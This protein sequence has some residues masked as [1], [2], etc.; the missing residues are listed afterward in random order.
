MIVQTENI[1]A[2]FE[3][4]REIAK[5]ADA[6]KPIPSRK[7][8]NFGDVSEM[9]AFLTPAR[10][11]LPE[12]IREH[13]GSIKSIAEVVRRKHSAVARDIAALRTF[14]LV[15]VEREINPGHGV[16]NIVHAEA[17]TLELVARI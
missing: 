17:K 16:H 4:G 8:I 9:L 1:D 14:G 10:I 6:G 15:R 12:T 11:S 2:F 7:I 5:L 3:R 13:P